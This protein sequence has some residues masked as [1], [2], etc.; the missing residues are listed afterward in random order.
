MKFTVNVSIQNQT[1]E[2]IYMQ[3]VYYQPPHISSYYFT[4]VNADIAIG[5]RSH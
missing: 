4:F 5:N 3:H 1:K 2:E